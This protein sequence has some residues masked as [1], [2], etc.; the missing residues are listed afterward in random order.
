MSFL[1]FGVI[2]FAGLALA[3]GLKLDAFYSH[4]VG[5]MSGTF[6]WFACDMLLT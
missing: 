1:I 5:W 2:Y 3:Y 4:A 6:A